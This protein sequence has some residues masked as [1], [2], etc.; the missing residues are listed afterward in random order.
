MDHFFILAHI[1][2]LDIVRMDLALQTGCKNSIKRRSTPLYTKLDNGRVG[3][4]LSLVVRGRVPELDDVITGGGHDVSNG[5]LIA[6]HCDK[7]SCDE[8]SSRNRCLP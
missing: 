6:L 2:Q 7:I 8:G 5:L 4:V 3:C 1:L